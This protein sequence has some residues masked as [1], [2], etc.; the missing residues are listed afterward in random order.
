M[1]PYQK[2]DPTCFFSGKLLDHIFTPA[3]VTSSR[4]AMLLTVTWPRRC[5]SNQSKNSSRLCPGGLIWISCSLQ[6]HI[7][8]CDTVCICLCCRFAVLLIFSFDQV[9]M[10]IPMNS[11]QT[12]HL[13]FF[14]HLYTS[15]HIYIY[16][17]TFIH[18][19][20]LFV[21]IWY[22]YNVQSILIYF[23]SN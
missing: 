13:R 18:I 1:K 11:K 8:K 12:T 20:N 19:Y 22:E 9:F 16:I 23:C 21:Y 2:Y 3:S 10:F 7:H 6:L 5:C 15:I 17:R 4:S 14:I